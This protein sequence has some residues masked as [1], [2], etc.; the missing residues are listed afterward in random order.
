P[1]S[2]PR[3]LDAQLVASD[4]AADLAI[5]RI[6]KRKALPYVARLGLNPPEPAPDSVVTS[7]GFDLGAKLSSWPSR[8]VE[9]LWF[10][11]NESQDERKFLITEKPPEHGR[12]G[13]GL[14][15]AN[16]ELVGVCLGYAELV[17]GRP[18]GVFASGESI[19]NLILD[20]N[21]TPV[22]AS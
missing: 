3:T 18:M 11:L 15:L 13:G 20:H 16:G 4:P 2:W 9:I 12:S 19:R 6:A 5:L 7:I 8:L 14:F 17:P 10:E 22:L 21:L 1:G